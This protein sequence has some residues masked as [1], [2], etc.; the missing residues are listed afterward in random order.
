MTYADAEKVTRRAK[1]FI[2]DPESQEYTDDLND[3]LEYADNRINNQIK[4]TALPPTTPNTIK[5]IAFLFAVSRLLDTYAI[6]GGERN[7]IAIAFEKQATEM[8]NN[9]PRDENPDAESQHKYTITQTSKSRPWQGSR[10][11]GRRH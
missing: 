9:Y 1:Q 5:E 6:A 3:A 2:D 7:E 10:T 4:E 8:L 11:R